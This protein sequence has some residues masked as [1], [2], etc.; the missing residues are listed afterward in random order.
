MSRKTEFRAFGFGT[1]MAGWNFEK[2]W[3]NWPKT[4]R[5]R[6]QRKRKCQE[7]EIKYWFDEKSCQ[8]NKIDKWRFQMF[9][10][11]S[12]TDLSK[13]F[14]SRGP[15]RH[16]CLDFHAKYL[17]R[18]EFFSWKINFTKILLPIHAADIM[19]MSIRVKT[20]WSGWAM[21]FWWNWFH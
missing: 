8:T 15:F 17:S 6:H 5:I 3:N 13:S 2:Y 7:K 14:W 21:K 16:S 19:L 11:Q 12:V 10:L 9:S 1:W 20:R 18:Y 4:F